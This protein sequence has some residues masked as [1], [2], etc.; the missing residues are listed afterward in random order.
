MT[1]ILQ[2]Q[3]VTKG[4]PGVLALD[5]ISF[6]IEPGHCHAIVGENGAGKS[7]L[8]R[9]VAGIYRPDAGRML[10]GGREV[11]FRSPLA[12]AEAGIAIVHQELAFCGN[13][14]VAENLHLGKPPSSIGRLRWREMEFSA[15]RML[16]EVGLS[17]DPW[18]PMETLSTAQEQL[19]QIAVAVGRQARVIIMDE[20]TSSLSH[21]EVETLFG[22][23]QRLRREGVTI[24]YVSHRLEEIKRLCDRVTVLRDGRFIETLVASETPTDT[25]VQRMVGRPIAEYFPTHAAGTPGDV[26]LSVKRLSGPAGFRDVS[27]DVRAGEILGLAGLVGAGRS[28]VARAIFGID[29]IE[30]GTVQLEGRPLSV[31]SARDAIRVGIGLL[32]ED[33]KRQGLILSMNCRENIT[34]SLLDTSGRP[35][36]S[37]PRIAGSRS[38]P[39]S[40]RRAGLFVNHARDRA[41][42]SE[43]CDRLRVRTRDLDAEIAGLSGGN[44]QKVAL[45]KWLARRCRV[46]ILDEPTRGVDVAAKAEIHALIDELAMAGHAIILISSEL[47]EILNLSTRILVL[48]GGRLVGELPR[49]QA[50]QER[51]MRLMA[52]VDA[53]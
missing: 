13:L 9:I 31:R 52:G 3:G 21:A 16:A 17:I 28:E 43:Y 4:F 25:I 23:L 44:Q 51:L 11:S 15:E 40:V 2:F 6:T 39:L 26:L 32:P 42:A 37:A 30:S 14:S 50:N 7:T 46:L 34:L 38:D 8:G 48:A 19:C 12:A 27:F 47:P 1:P 45:A 20:P 18:R 36:E 29:P 22:I 53:A 5:D 35:G 10:L 24:L 41:I 49:A 33:R